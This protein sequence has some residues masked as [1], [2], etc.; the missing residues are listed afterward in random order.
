MVTG[1]RASRLLKN[2]LN[3]NEP[4]EY[5]KYISTSS[6]SPS[7]TTLPTHVNGVIRGFI[8]SSKTAKSNSNAGTSL[9]NPL[10][11]T[12]IGEEDEEALNYTDDVSMSQN[13]HGIL[14]DN[15]EAFD[16]V[17]DVSKLQNAFEAKTDHL[18][19]IFG[20]KGC[21]YD[22]CKQA[23]R[24]CKD[25]SEEAFN[26]LD[27]KYDLLGSDGFVELPGS[28]SGS[29]FESSRLGGRS[30]RNIFEDLSGSSCGHLFESSKRGRY[31][32]PVAGSS[33]PHENG[34]KRFQAEPPIRLM[35]NGRKR[36]AECSPVSLSL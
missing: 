1:M 8:F 24:R 3:Y 22:E 19:Q 14:G 27:R 7:P 11:L 12:Y 15:R 35:S 28:T 31:D 29:S 32:G 18:Q 25:D 34:C 21:S 23:L 20:I 17:D 30:R 6:P 36:G 10:N 5:I 2:Q 16:G 13:G 4:S 33:H 26:I 9:S